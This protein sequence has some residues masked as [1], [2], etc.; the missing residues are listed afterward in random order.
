MLTY[1]ETIKLDY[2]K[3][4]APDMGHETTLT[5]Y[6]PN[7]ERHVAAYTPKRPTVIVLPGGGYTNISSREADPIVIR[8]LA[9]GFNVGLLNYSCKPS[10]FPTA[11]LEAL[12]AIKYI[13]DNA[14]KNF[15]DPNQIYL[16]GFSAGGHL[17]ASCGTHWHRAESE[18]YFGDV[19]RVKPNGLILCY[20]VITSEDEAHSG[21]IRALLGDKYTDEE[22][23]EY[24]SLEKQVDEKTPTSFI[25]ST[26]YDQSVPCENA[27]MFASALRKAGTP[28][29]LH[30]FEDGPHGVATGDNVTTPMLFPLRTRSWIDMSAD[31]IYENVSKPEYVVYTPP[32]K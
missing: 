17:A 13:R 18:R 3:L 20:A 30:I 5:L 29:E 24:V 16:C 22:A 1:N 21:S 2:T 14:E 7:E 25:W 6:V 32:L 27:I 15:S 31:W 23:R 12:S 10:V 9:R 8:Y 19:E 4:D 26:F 11:L 28:F